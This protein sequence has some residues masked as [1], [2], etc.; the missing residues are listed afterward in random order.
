VKDK[1]MAELFDITQARASETSTIK[2]R[3]GDD[4][5][6][7]GKDGKTQLSITV[8]GPG[9]RE[10]NEATS[11]R[12]N[13]ALDKL[14]RKG[15]MDQ[16]ADE[17]I[18]EEATFLTAITVSFNGFGYPPA[19]DLSGAALFKAVYSDPTLGFIKDQVAEFAGDWENFTGGSATS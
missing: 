19:G 4:S 12:Q 2:L 11:R 10:Y 16:T 5:P 15:K 8:Y 13:R 17:K 6:L 14:K 3:K 18:A 7:M 1:Y 9:S